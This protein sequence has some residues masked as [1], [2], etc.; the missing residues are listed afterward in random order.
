VLERRLE[1]L[2]GNHARTLTAK[3]EH[4]L[5][6]RSAGGLLPGM[7]TSDSVVDALAASPRYAGCDRLE[8]DLISRASTPVAVAAGTVLTTEGRRRAE[9]VIVLAGTAR[10]QR[11]GTTVAA[12]GPGDHFGEIALLRGGAS[13]ATIVAAGAMLLAVVSP[14]DFDELLAASPA[15]ARAVFGELAGRVRAA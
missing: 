13:R 6:Q 3:V 12:L 10:V 7:T 9:F 15:V 1:F 8:L 2:A 5:Y 14:V 11:A 4:V